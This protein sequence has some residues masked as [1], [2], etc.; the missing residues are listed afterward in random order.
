MWAFSFAADTLLP[1][2]M[3]H[4]T[5]VSV[6][7]IL[8][9]G[10]V[11]AP[12]KSKQFRPAFADNTSQLQAVLLHASLKYCFRNKP[13]PPDFAAGLDTVVQMAKQQ[14]ELER[15]RVDSS[16]ALLQQ[17]I[18]HHLIVVEEVGGYVA[19]ISAI[20]WRAWRLEWP[21]SLIGSELGVTKRYVHGIVNSLIRS[22]QQLGFETYAPHVKKG[23]IKVD[24]DA[25]A[26]TWAA[27]K[28]VRQTSERL[29]LDIQTVY[30][31]LNQ[32]GL[33]PKRK[34]T[35]HAAIAAVW[36]EKKTIRAVV[37]AL[38]YAAETIVHSL[39]LQNLRV[40]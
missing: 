18:Y 30:K 1:S 2:S 28:S 24:A 15:S 25:V 40:R 29:G 6:D 22:A 34:P 9:M 39:R 8:S 11:R 12:S 27:C 31:V 23:V 10:R 14:L 20:A 26:A 7:E 19:M 17:R 37:A 38:G 13:M 33:R 21:A 32:L 36:A 3:R 4:Q 16:Q 5:I 35:D